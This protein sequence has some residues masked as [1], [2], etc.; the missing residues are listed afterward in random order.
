MYERARAVCIGCPVQV[1]CGR[2][3]LELL[4]RD[5][6]DGMYGGMEP[7]RLRSVARAIAR[8][9]RKVARHGSRPGYVRGCRCRPCRNANAAYE[10]ARRKRKAA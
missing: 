5:S 8:S 2:L 9:A 4:N 3:G 6:V 10:S 7:D 1:Q